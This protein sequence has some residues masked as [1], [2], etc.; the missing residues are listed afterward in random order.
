[1]NNIREKLFELKEENY[2]KFSSRL[3]VSKYELLG[4]RLPYLRKLAKELDENYL[5][6]EHKYFEEIMLEG[7][8]IGNFK[9]ISKTLKQLSIFVSKIDNWSICDSFCSS[10][11]ITKKYPKQVFKFIKKYQNSKLEFEKRFLLVMLLNYYVND[12]YIDDIFL[13]IQKIDKTEYY[14]KM[15]VAWLLSICYLSYENKVI[16]YLIHGKLDAFTIN[17]TISKIC[18][19]YRISN[20]KKM[21]IKKL[22][23][24]S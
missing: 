13:I 5:N 9:D 7:M 14:V 16:E 20:Q 3:V 23:V 6:Q 24:N 15:A 12:D 10:L 2:Q 19:S 1:M 22:R 17:K 4:V 18:D 11:K 21:E 8:I